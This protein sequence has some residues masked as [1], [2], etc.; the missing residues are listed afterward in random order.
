M[1][2]ASTFTAQ[3]AVVAATRLNSATL[4]GGTNFVDSTAN[5]A[6]ANTYHVRPVVNGAEQAASGSFTL[7][8]NKAVEPVVRIPIRSGGAIKF[9]GSVTLMATVSMTL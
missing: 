1:A 3:R 7:V 8:A 4:T 6:Q 9:V 5:L 2:S